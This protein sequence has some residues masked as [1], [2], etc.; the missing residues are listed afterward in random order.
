MKNLKKQFFPFLI[1]VTALSV[2]ASAAIY[3][4]SG[5][6]KLFAGAETQVMIMAGS[7]EVAKLIVASL[8]Y[9]YWK[10]LNRWFK[11]YFVGA[12]LV[13]MLIT[14][15]GIYGYL[16]AAYQE[17]A[18][19][20]QN[21]DTQIEL[22]ETKKANYIQQRDLYNTERGTLSKGISELQAG[23]AGN[24]IT[25]TDKNGNLVNT[26]SRATRQAFEKQL[27]N[28]TTRQEEV[29]V[30]LDTLNS[31]IFRL[32]TEIVEVKTSNN[33]SG[34]LGPLRYLAEVTGAPMSNIINWLLLVIIFVFD[35]LAIALVIAA[36]FAFDR[37]KAPKEEPK[38]KE[39]P[40]FPE[41]NVIGEWLAEHGDPKV[42][43]QYEKLVLTEVDTEAL[44]DG[45]ENPE[46]PNEAL[47]EAMKSYK[48]TL[49]LADTQKQGKRIKKV[50]EKGHY[51]TKVEFEDGTTD[52]IPN[53]IHPEKNKIV[54]MS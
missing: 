17:T 2:S 11:T 46:P 28:S 5:L 36:N 37:L 53:S 40:K 25:Y 6:S 20:S 39:S 52:W 33:L 31:R 54:Y 12:L 35:P 38:S 44:L 47:V 22:L 34:E 29:I 50:I 21:V 1:A 13:L 7:L 45:I 18:N 19:K 4:V 30:K 51:R 8:L 43:E 10:E 9:Q 16:S 3:S 15:M 48:D 26:T 24:R 42:R 14:S 23:L 49:H 32:D 41:N 27:N